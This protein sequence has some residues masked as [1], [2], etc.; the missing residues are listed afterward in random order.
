MTASKVC[1]HHVPLFLWLSCFCKVVVVAKGTYGG[2]YVVAT[3]SSRSGN[4]TLYLLSL[5]VLFPLLLVG[6]LFVNRMHQRKRQDRFLQE[7]ETAK[8]AVLRD[9]TTTKQVLSDSS[10]FGSGTFMASYKNI[11]RGGGTYSAQGIIHFGIVKDIDDDEGM[12]SRHTRSITG[13][14]TN[15]DGGFEIAEGMLSVVSGTCYWIQ[16]EVATATQLFL[17]MAVVPSEASS[18][19]YGQLW[20]SILFGFPWPLVQYHWSQW[21]LY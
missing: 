14:G 18:S 17:S 2:G 1:R 19:R 21:Y 9:I 7:V 13:K 16:A 5:V 10:P 8:A 15:D 12:K 3:G 20:D 6:M 4:T 11:L